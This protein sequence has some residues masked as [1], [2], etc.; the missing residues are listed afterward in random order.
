M[1]KFKFNLVPRRFVNTFR[2]FAQN[3]QNTHIKDKES[4]ILANIHSV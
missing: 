2:N 4:S 3:V 1:I